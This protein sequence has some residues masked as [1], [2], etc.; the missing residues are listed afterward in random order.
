MFNSEDKVKAEVK[1][2]QFKKLKIFFLLHE[3]TCRMLAKCFCL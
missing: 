1:L 3:F 2:L